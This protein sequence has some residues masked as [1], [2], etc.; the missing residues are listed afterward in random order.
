[1][2]KKWRWVVFL[3]LV[4]FASTSFSLRCGTKLIDEGDSITKVRGACGDPTDSSSYREYSPYVIQHYGGSVPPAEEGDL[5]EQWIY[6]FGPQRFVYI[7]TFRNGR[8]DEIKT[9]DYGD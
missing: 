5:I 2:K 9:D 4:G 6:N 8:L 1:M 3:M 7:L